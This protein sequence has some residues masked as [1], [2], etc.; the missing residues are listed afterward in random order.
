VSDIVAYLGKPNV[1][2]TAYQDTHLQIHKSLLSMQDKL[3][4]NAPLLIIASS[5]G[6]EIISN[7]I[8]DR[9]RTPGENGFGDTPFERLETLTGMVML[10]N[11]SPLYFPSYAIDELKPFTF[12]PVQLPERY[13]KV[14]YWGNFYDKNDPLGF[15]IKPVNR[16]YNTANVEDVQLN[17][18]G[19]II[20]WNAAS[21]LGYWKSRAVLKRTTKLIKDVIT[22]SET[23]EKKKC[24]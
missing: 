11:I 8:Y 4:P 6:T 3:I 15:P 7:Y 23:D 19:W 13:K 9:Q 24:A 1:A 16:N 2:G 22:V 17:A 5:L 21:H 12:P 14:S 18:G 10:G 20:S